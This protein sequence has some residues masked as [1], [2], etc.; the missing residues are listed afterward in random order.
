MA[1]ITA[2][3]KNNMW[4]RHDGAKVMF[5]EKRKSLGKIQLLTRYI[6]SHTDIALFKA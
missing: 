3:Q 6:Y 2:K 5:E 4:H 1:A